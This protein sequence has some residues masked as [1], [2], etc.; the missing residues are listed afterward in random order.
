MPQIIQSGAVN[1]TA[2]VVPDLYVQ[3]VPPANQS[4]NGVPTDVLG[5]VG[6][7]NWGP[8][9]VPVII[10]DMSDY[11]AD[12]GQIQNRKYD[13]GTAVAIAVQQGAQNF[14][15]VRVTDGTDSAA[16]LTI[17][18]AITLTAL[19]TGS[20]GNYINVWLSTGSAAGSYRATITIP[21][22]Q[23]EIFD[24]LTGTTTTLWAN[25]AA[26]INNGNSAIR[27]P[28][29]IFRAVATATAAT[30]VVGNYPFSAGTAGTDGVTT[31]TDAVLLGVDT[32]P[33]T[34][35]YALRSQG[36]GVAMLADVTSYTVHEAEMAFGLSENVYMILADAAGSAL[37]STGIAT[38]TTNKQNAGI[39]SYDC[40]IMFGDWI[41][42]Y[43]QVNA[44]TRLVSPQAFA[45]GRLV[46]LSPEQSSLNKPIY[47]VL[48]TQK[49]GYVG[50]GQVLTYANADLGAL[51]QAG[52]DVIT[53]NQPGGNFWGCRIGH[54]SSSNAAIQGDNYTRLTNYISRTL[55]AG[56][57]VYVGQLVN[58][59]LFTNIKATLLS[60]LSNL[61]SQGIL[62]STD[63]SLPFGVTCNLTNNPLSRTNLGYVQ[64][65]V[66]VQYQAI[67]EK[68]IVNVEAGQTVTVTPVSGIAQS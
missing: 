24:N 31:I 66:Q 30:L 59:K 34:G 25:M 1:T 45:A 44:V 33:R 14:R 61:L 48:G 58:A 2:L 32:L 15:C 21:G 9:G 12:F 6:T 7:A 19:Y 18:S 38:A 60:F 23:P 5:I 57:G 39:D 53:N 50:S 3:I 22:Y 65:D 28:S 35:M 49:T 43:D 67:N 68:F 16:V 55:A 29:Q 17:L 56:M 11:A 37:S 54:N 62:G 36:C 42:W 13:M 41:Y 10:G 52:F 64:A 47:G 46:N 40:K 8:V 26:A 27:G 51:E 4:I 20:N 63:G